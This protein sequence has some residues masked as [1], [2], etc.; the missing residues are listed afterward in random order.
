[1]TPITLDDAEHQLRDALDTGDPDRI[2]AATDLVD[3]LDQPRPASLHAAALWYAEQGLK[4]FPLTPGTKVPFK[5]SN[6]CKGASSNHDVVDGWWSDS[7][8][9][10]IGLATGHLVDVVDIDGP[11]GVRSFLQVADDL[12]HVF[13]KVLTPRAGGMHLYVAAV[14][15]R[16][17]RA[18]IL[19][20]LDYRGDGGYVVAPPSVNEQGMYRWLRPLDVA[21][22]RMEGAA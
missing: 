9:A 16:G 4:V 5:G 19:P 14:P 7:P 2:A 22:L 17:N 21:A 11:D 12:P 1:M 10:N 6:G 3:R 15:G 20:H 13:G 18:G 8:D